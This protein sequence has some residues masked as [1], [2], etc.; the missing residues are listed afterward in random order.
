MHNSNAL[1]GA[2]D[3]NLKRSRPEAEQQV[4]EIV[5]QLEADGRQLARRRAAAEHSGPVAALGKHFAARGKWAWRWTCGSSCLLSILC[6][7][8]AVAP[9]LGE[10]SKRALLH[11]CLN[12]A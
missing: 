5:E 4:H 7:C 6:A 8:E 12:A 2:D 3:C 9:V 1:C 11:S 10:V